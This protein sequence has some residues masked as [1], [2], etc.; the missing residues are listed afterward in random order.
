MTSRYAAPVVAL[1]CA[2]ALAACTGTDRAAQTALPAAARPL[3]AH[4]VHISEYKIPKAG[5]APYY[6]AMGP[7]GNR[8]VWFTQSD[9]LGEMGMLGKVKE[10]PLPAG[11][12]PNGITLG[13]DHHLWFTANHKY[14]HLGRWSRK[15]PAFYHVGA[16]CCLGNIV[17]GPDG[18]LWF[19]AISYYRQTLQWDYIFRATT[20]GSISAYFL[21]A[22]SSSSV[23]PRPTSIASGSDGA[24]WFTECG[25]STI[26][27]ITTGGVVTNTYPVPSGGTP[28][29]ITGGPDGALWFTESGNKIGR[30]DVS[31]N[32]NEFGGLSGDGIGITAGPD[33]A[34]WFT[35]TSNKIGRMTISG[36]LT[37][38]SIPTKGSEPYFI[39][40]DPTGV[41]W[42]TEHHAYKI[43]RISLN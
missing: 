2:S 26:G 39:T 30:I 12:F 20:T 21:N 24:L 23:Y 32:L 17:N 7:A 22:N 41:L 38:Y 35:E 3:A 13:S 15:G 5:G 1:A 33:G 18:A 31:G 42:F 40:S 43:G 29:Y 9:A 36:S 27:R 14:T 28:Y 4:A 19:P 10:H 11:I 25:E 8:G 37:E 6:I 34:L 16:T